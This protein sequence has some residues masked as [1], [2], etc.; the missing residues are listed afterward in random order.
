[1]MAPG[2][3]R[4]EMRVQ[5]LSKALGAKA[6]ICPS[7]GP[8]GKQRCPHQGL[9]PGFPLP[10]EVAAELGYFSLSSA[11]HQAT[12]PSSR[13]A[14]PRQ[15]QFCSFSCSFP[16]SQIS[17]KRNLKVHPPKATRNPKIIPQHLHLRL[18]SASLHLPVPLRLRVEQSTADNSLRCFQSPALCD[19]GTPASSP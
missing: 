3:T 19:A 2:R 17:R 18:V 12:S 9:R 7:R 8:E 16:S 14:A 11:L 1:M 15:K 13:F 5:T 6:E 4:A 10:L